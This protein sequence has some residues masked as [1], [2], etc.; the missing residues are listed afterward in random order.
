MD[1]M[2]GVRA[3]VLKTIDMRNVVEGTGE[4][5]CLVPREPLMQCLRSLVDAACVVYEAEVERVVESD[6][7]DSATVYYTDFSG[8]E[9]SVN[10]RV[11][12][13]ADGARSAMRAKV[14]EQAGGDSRVNFCGEVCYRG[15]VR[16]DDKMIDVEA[17]RSLFPDSAAD[18]TMR[19]NYGAGLRSSFGYMSNPGEDE[20]AYWWVKQ[21]VDTMPTHRG[22][23]ANCPWPEPL[24][25]LHNATP[26][27]SFYVHAIEDSAV[28]PKWSSTRIVLAGDAAHA[29][30]PNMGQGAC[31][32]IEDG[33]VLATQLV[34]FWSERDGHLEAF[35]EY[36][37]LR[38]P[39]ATA[40]KGEARTQLLLG[41]LSHPLAV[42]AR[43]M[44]LR[45]I[46]AVILEKKLHRQNFAIA[47][48]L[49]LYRE[50]GPV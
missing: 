26:D 25:S 44:F 16:L 41:Q 6:E 35:Y 47:P 7:M 9:C 14:V 24:R 30:T 20:L 18:R 1:F 5:F 45:T 36:E 10:A 3:D 23:M 46:P 13:G 34:R 49:D 29:V 50:I 37:R 17:M 2:G 12:V 19:I 33:F 27:G 39:G 48:A 32:G 28:L 22:K 43:D 8:R 42:R 4:R 21:V 31:M 11:V 40:V 15:I 38:K